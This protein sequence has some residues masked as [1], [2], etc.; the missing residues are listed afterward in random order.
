MKN[1]DGVY[2]EESRRLFSLASLITVAIILLVAISVFAISG[3]L[4]HNLNNSLTREF[5]ERVRAEGN[6]IGQALSN[7][8]DAAHGRLRN[9]ALDNTVRVTLMLETSRQLGEYLANSYAGEPD[10]HFFVTDPEHKNVFVAGDAPFSPE[11]IAHFFSAPESGG[12]IEN[13]V[14]RLGF[15]YS[16]TCPVKRRQETIGTGAVVYQLNRDRYLHKIMAGREDNRL[17]LV[18]DKKIWDLLSGAI[19]AELDTAPTPTNASIM[20]LE[21]DGRS[22]AAVPR[23]EFRDLYYIADLNRLF[24]ARKQ[25]LAS[26]LLPSAIV[27]TLAVFVSVLISG[28]VSRPLQQLSRL[29]LAIAAKGKDSTGSVSATRIVEF[30]R[31]RSSLDTMVDHLEHAREME[32]YQELFDNVA[33]IVIIHDL[34]GSIVDAN[35]VAVRQL[36]ASGHSLSGRRLADLVP[37]DFASNIGQ[38]LDCLR[39]GGEKTIFTTRIRDASGK[40]LYVE[41]HARRIVYDNREVVLNVLRDINDRKA[42]ENALEESQRILTTVLDSI[43]ATIYVCDVGSHEILFM[44]RQMIETYGENAD[45]RTCYRFIKNSDEPCE[46]CPAKNLLQDRQAMTLAR[47]VYNPVVDRWFMSYDRLIGWIDGRLAKFQVSFDISGLKRLEAQREQAQAQ[48]RKAQKMEAIATLAGG[49]AHDLNNILSGIVSFPDLLLMQVKKDDPMHRPLTTI[50]DAGLRASAIVQDLLTLARRGVV[51][52]EVVNLNEIVAAYL[53]SP[54]HQR[55]MSEHEGVAIVLD[56]QEDLFN[57]IGSSLHLSN[58]IM[59]LVANGVEAIEKQGTLRISTLVEVVGPG[60]AAT[61]DMKSG[62]Y[63]VLRIADDGCGIEEKSRS[64]IFEPFFTTKVM[65]KSGTGLGMAVVW[66]TVEDHEGY[67]DLQS[68][69]GKGTVF[70]L[71]FPLTRKKLLKEQMAF[72]SSTFK[73]NGETILVVDDVAELRDIASLM[74]TRLGYQVATAASG[75]EAVSY[76][77]GNRADLVLLDMVM[78]GGMNGLDTFRRILEIHPGQKAIITTGYS[79]IQIVQEARALG[80]GQYIKKPYLFE[81]IAK[82]VWTELHEPIPD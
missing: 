24:A 14:A 40:A 68:E 54:E 64:R 26:L 32:R 10:L 28:R 9:L 80:A 6:E 48:L 34:D 71:Y 73:G 4:F 67:I 25:V 51:V 57:I 11:E 16:V 66:G 74:F 33:D 39:R 77:S 17:V 43:Q 35:Q 61:I 82:A 8:I 19:L 21:L 75:E 1:N 60:K 56:L 72:S 55:L 70:T 79:E 36:E 53:E 58:T 20:R 41:C 23:E 15:S 65:G 5:E 62:E 52:N 44:N 81:E 38:E 63:V 7:R 27:I 3:V 45:N 31:F 22:F 76:L 13:I 37:D 50:R 18:R 69:V 2:G 49:V 59:N 42:A 30:E 46:N 47:E 78:E 12:N 29:A